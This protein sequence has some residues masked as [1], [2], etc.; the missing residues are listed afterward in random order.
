MNLNLVFLAMLVFFA[1]INTSITIG[2]TWRG[3]R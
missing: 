3:H 1:M 2:K